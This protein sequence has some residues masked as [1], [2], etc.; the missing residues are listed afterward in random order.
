MV[1]T[2]LLLNGLGDFCCRDEPSAVLVAVIVTSI[3]SLLRAP[4][5]RHQLMGLYNV[6]GDR[7]AL[8]SRHLV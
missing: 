4:W 3:S 7:G 8:R 1:L 6:S 5:R 2:A